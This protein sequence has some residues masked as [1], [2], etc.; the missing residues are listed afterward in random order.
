MSRVGARG[1]S[2]LVTTESS[3]R[4]T[5]QGQVHHDADHLF[6]G[7]RTLT[8]T[9]SMEG[10]LQP[11]AVRVAQGI[12]CVSGFMRFLGCGGV[13]GGGRQLTKRA[14][15]ASSG[16]CGTDKVTRACVRAHTVYLHRS[17]PRGNR[18]R[19]PTHKQD[20]RG[21]ECVC[22]RVCVCACE[23]G[24]FLVPPPSL[25]LVLW[26]IQTNTVD[27]FVR[28]GSCVCIDLRLAHVCHVNSTLCEW[29]YN[30][31]HPYT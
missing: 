3:L 20:S 11:Q 12:R 7:E 28:T 25:N 23:C 6:P 16:G 17:W 26:S 31:G 1:G 5:R 2:A 22:V 19:Q 18:G 9:C 10:H 24:R 21:A 8:T 4:D 15:V 29:H 13:T 30:S 14:L 27:T